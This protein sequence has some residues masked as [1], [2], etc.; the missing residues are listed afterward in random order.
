[1]SQ[2]RIPVSTPNKVTKNFRDISQSLRIDSGVVS[3]NG[4]RR[5]LQYPFQHIVHC[6]AT[7]DILLPNMCNN[8]YMC[9]YICIYICLCVCVCV[10]IYEIK[11][12]II[13]T[14]RCHGREENSVP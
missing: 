14:N 3:R 12:I 10:C 13:S 7:I 8:R 11:I 5:F 6:H 4:N 9:V 1:M 2:I